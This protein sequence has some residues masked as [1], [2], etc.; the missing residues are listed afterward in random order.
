MQNVFQLGRTVRH[1]K[2]AQLGNKF[3]YQLVKFC[4]D[5]NIIA[6]PKGEYPEIKFLE[7]M[8]MAYTCSSLTD[9]GF[10]FLG[11]SHTFKDEIDWNIKSNGKLWNIRLNSFDYLNYHNIDPNEG[12]TVILD[13]IRNFKKNKTRFDAHCASLRVIN[14]IKFV[15]RYKIDEA[16][17]N[18]FLFSQSIYILKNSELHLRNNHLL[19]NAFALL[20]AADYFQ[21]NRMHK[22]AGKLLTRGLKEQILDDGAHFELCPMYHI[23]VVNRMLEAIQVL[24][25][26]SFAAVTLLESLT[27][28]TSKMLGWISQMQFTNGTLPSINDSAAGYGPSVTAILKT[29]GELGLQSRVLPLKQSGF[30]KFR[31]R[32][33]EL[34]IDVNGL[35]PSEAPGHAHADTFNFV[36]N[37]FGDPFIIDTGVSTYEPG[38]QR[39]YERSTMAHNTVVVNG[40][41]QSEVYGSFRAGRRAKVQIT[42]SSADELEAVHDGY[43]YL[44]VRHRRSFTFGKD[45]IVIRDVIESKSKVQCSAFLHIDK[46][47]KVALRDGAFLSRFCKI[48]FINGTKSELSEGT[49]SPAFGQTLPCQILKTDFVGELVTVISLG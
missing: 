20:F 22:Y 17:I 18:S 9:S 11:K 47:N 6:P 42:K 46:K 10:S 44:G 4:Y 29:A 45:R 39:L 21:D 8:P 48:E 2:A 13:F 5:K 25:R 38:P 40:K 12:K 43:N 36:L 33:F 32:N 31:N 37:I 30:R 28:Y 7:L 14:T 23:W 24:R 15:S 26:T 1:F 27:K 3:Q 19:E 34:L 41:N 16:E 49:F 35:T